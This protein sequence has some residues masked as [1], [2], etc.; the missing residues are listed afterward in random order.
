MNREE[1]LAERQKRFTAAMS[2]L[3]HQTNFTHFIDAIRMETENALDGLTDKEVVG[4]LQATYAA[5][6]EITA[7]RTMVKIYDEFRNR[8]AEREVEP[9]VE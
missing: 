9:P 3:V 1:Q 2:E 7:Y 5:I 8:P 4:N 6:G